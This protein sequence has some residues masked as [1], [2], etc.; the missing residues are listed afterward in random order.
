[1]LL[2][3]VKYEKTYNLAFGTNRQVGS[4]Y[5]A[6]VSDLLNNKWMFRLSKPIGMFRKLMFWIWMLFE[7]L[8]LG[9]GILAPY[10][11]KQIASLSISWS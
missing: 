9:F 5:P 8:E 7:I 11:Q 3:Q 10:P 1:L 6:L 4:K 2:S